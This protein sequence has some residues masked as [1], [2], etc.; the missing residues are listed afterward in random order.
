M[1]E[2]IAQLAKPELGLTAAEIADM[3]WAITLCHRPGES[4]YLKNP[5]SLDRGSSPPSPPDMNRL[6]PPSLPSSPPVIPARPVQTVGDI[7]ETQEQKIDEAVTGP[8]LRQAGLYPRRHQ[9][10]QT[11]SAQAEASLIRVPNARSLRGNP[12]GIA[13]ALR[14]LIRTS[15]SNVNVL[16]DEPATVQAIAETQVWQTITKPQLEPWLDLALVV[17]ESP[18]ML[19]WR[20][21]VKELRR[22]FRYYGAFRD[23]R[24]WGLVKNGNQIGIRPDFWE[25]IESCAI[26]RPQ[27]LLDPTGR[28]LI[29]VATDCVDP[30]WHTKAMFDTLEVWAKGGPLAIVQMLPQW[31]WD[32]TALRQ[33]TASCL[34]GLEPGINNHQL[35]RI[36]IQRSLFDD[37]KQL[38]TGIAVP[39]LTPKSD[40]IASW[41]KMITGRGS[42]VQTLGV[43]FN[44]ADFP[45]EQLTEPASNEPTVKQST[46]SASDHPTAKQRIQQFRLATSPMG[47]RLARLLASAPVISLPVIRL[48]QE[49][50]L[51]N[52]DQEHVAEVLLG[53]I[54]KPQDTPH[55]DTDPENVVYSFIDPDIRSLL[56][57]ETPINDMVQVLS[58]YINEKL[59]QTLDEFL[60]D[61]RIDDS[62]DP[63]ENAEL[64]AKL[65]PFAI[66]TAE[67][68]KR[69]GGKYRELAKQLEADY[70][71]AIRIEKFS[72]TTIT[73]IEFWSGLETQQQSGEAYIFSEQLKPISKESQPITGKLCIDLVKIPGGNFLM[74]APARE[75]EHE[76]EEEPQH[77]VTISEFWMGRYPITQAQWR[78]VAALPQINCHLEPNGFHFQG[79]FDS[80]LRPAERVS[81]LEAVEFCDRLSKYTAR[82]YRL[83]SEA[84]WEYA[85]RAVEGAQQDSEGSA[86]FH[87]GQTLTPDLANYN[88][89]Y[90]YGNKKPETKIKWREQTTNVGYFSA[91]AFGLYDMH[92]NVSEW[93]ADHWQNSYKTVPQ[94]GNSW[95]DDTLPQNAPRVLRGGSWDI[96]PR[97]CRSA[98]RAKLAANERNY[99]T[100]FR[101]VLVEKS[102]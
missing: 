68:L 2:L 38:S 61:L 13:R 64:T 20:Q 14:P 99:S 51:P 59:D 40:Q 30:I 11:L 52:S 18:S 76:A 95:Q 28:R 48:V 73:R 70:G 37:P 87:Y 91:N 53:G 6:V 47:W 71:A 45:Q 36:A 12:L 33:A 85:C 22:F 79:D 62:S 39:I 49:T 17:D 81:W 58:K 41:S 90:I 93:C 63:L 44:R 50:L 4:I 46:K 69:K 72:Y 89:N 101:L 96:P 55:L 75:A 57:D 31:L 83:P 88:G 9:L 5:E 100:G 32:R 86:P 26:R 15:P 84:E 16:L 56:L 43:V 92:G 25:N 34:Y 67:V 1:D 27:E 21:T 78:A 54:L 35:Q 10:G 102:V 29:L 82:T 19:I 66:V 98:R 60:A 74:G 42:A 80:N 7:P 8:S 3:I 65:R 97:F 23:M 24:V 77:Q 94:D